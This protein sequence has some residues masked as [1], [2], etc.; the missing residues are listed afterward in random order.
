MS[1][2]VTSG[3]LVQGP[4]VVQLSAGPVPVPHPGRRAAHTPAKAPSARCTHP[5]RRPAT[6]PAA[7]HVIVLVDGEPASNVEIAHIRGAVLGSPRYDAAMTDDERR[8]FANLILLCTSHRKVVDR[9]HPGDYPVDVL[10][11]WKA[12]HEREAGSMAL[13][14]R[15]SPKIVSMISSRRQWPRPEPSGF[16]RSNSD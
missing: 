5:R 6:S 1:I 13:S 8:S 14:G 3:E 9:L 2:P 7:T 16:S 15:R 12:Q 4:S 11:G 10:A